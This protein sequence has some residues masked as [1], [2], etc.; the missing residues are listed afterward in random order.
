MVVETD[1]RNLEP[2][3]GRCFSLG[4]KGRIQ[5][6]IAQFMRNSQAESLHQRQPIY[7]IVGFRPLVGQNGAC[8]KSHHR[9][10]D[11]MIGSPIGACLIDACRMP[12]H[13]GKVFS[14]MNPW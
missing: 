11:Q 8:A 12:M 2:R 14:H 10:S 4:R 9:A 13:Q 3:H 6:I 1:L 5:T 7:K